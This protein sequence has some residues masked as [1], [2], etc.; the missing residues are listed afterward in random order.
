M[1]HYR[2]SLYTHLKKMFFEID[3]MS[4]NALL[5]V[6][7]YT[8]NY[9]EESYL[10][11]LPFCL[12]VEKHSIKYFVHENL[13]RRL[14]IKALRKQKYFHLSNYQYFYS[15]KKLVYY[16]NGC[17]LELEPIVINS[18]VIVKKILF[19]T[20]IKST[21]LG[22]FLKNQQLFKEISPSILE[23]GTFFI[24]PCMYTKEYAKIKRVLSTE[25]DF[26]TDNFLEI[27]TISDIENFVF[28]KSSIFVEPPMKNVSEKKALYEEMFIEVGLKDRTSVNPIEVE[29][30]EE[31][32]SEEY[33]QFLNEFQD[34]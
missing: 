23:Q 13:P 9:K 31:V 22:I 24:D 33:L 8:F 17:L 5:S 27:V 34:E 20:T 30:K 32:L 26:C 1:K 6:Q 10:L 14:D 3:A 11:T 16:C 4:Q 18:A 25:L 28:K 19:C 15:N 12:D 21:H 2:L 29:E 7:N